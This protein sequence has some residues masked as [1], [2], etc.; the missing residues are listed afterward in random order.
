MEKHEDNYGSRKD[1][2][3]Y[4]IQASKSNLKSA[5]I[6]LEAGEYK[7]ANNRAYYAIFDAINAIHALDGNAYK[8]HG[9]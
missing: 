6:L 4:R 1:L 7:S 3:Q 8:R 5:R 9:E 2:V